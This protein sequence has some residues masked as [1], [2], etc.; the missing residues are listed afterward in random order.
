MGEL[1]VLLKGVISKG[2]NKMSPQKSR[3]E[4]GLEGIK[5]RREDVEKEREEVVAR[6]ET[7]LAGD[8]CG[9]LAG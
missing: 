7:A 4:L 1:E 6:C 2:Y 9:P 3:G 5:S 8:V